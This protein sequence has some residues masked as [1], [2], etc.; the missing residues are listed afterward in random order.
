M[1]KAKIHW[2]I[3]STSKTVQD[4]IDSALDPIG[5]L[6][7]KTIKGV[8]R[9]G[10]QIQPDAG[11]G[12]QPSLKQNSVKNR[13]RLSEYNKTHS[14]FSPGRSNLTFTGQLLDAVIYTTEQRGPQRIVK[15]TVDDTLRRP[16]ITSK[17]GSTSDQ[18]TN[19]ELAEFQH[20]KGRRFIAINKELKQMI[21]NLIR[22]AI[23][24]SIRNI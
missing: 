20:E 9:S 17:S 19:S 12:T 23:R 18:I 14:T 13:K 2:K 10:G 22:R 3:Q 4:A 24:R 16:Y 1:A 7:V 21:L 15:I 6:A 5:K 8:T 11:T